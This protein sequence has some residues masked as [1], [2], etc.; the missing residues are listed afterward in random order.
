VKGW[1]GATEV[2]TEARFVEDGP[3]PETKRKRIGSLDRVVGRQVSGIEI[4]TFDTR[5]CDRETARVLEIPPND[6]IRY[7]ER[8]IST[9]DGP[10]AYLRNF[11]PLRI[12]GGIKRKELEATFLRDV[13]VKHHGVPIDQGSG[14]GRGP[15]GRKPYRE[16]AQ[17]QARES[18]AADRAAVH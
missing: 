7:A 8:L 18:V 17:D 16:V 11:L 9:A 2:D 4:L 10:V 1:C 3:T 5:T 12:G 13:L 14:R 6:S 15:I